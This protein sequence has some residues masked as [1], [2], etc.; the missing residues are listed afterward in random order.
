MKNF[1]LLILSNFVLYTATASVDDMILKRLKELSQYYMQDF[2]GIKYTEVVVEDWQNPKQRGQLTALY[3]IDVDNPKLA[4][5][6]N[7]YPIQDLIKNIDSSKDFE[8]LARIM[9]WTHSRWKHNSV[10]NPSSYAATT[11][12]REA[13]QGGEFVCSAYSSVFTQIA[14]ALG[15]PARPF[16][17]MGWSLWDF[18][19]GHSQTEAWS[20]QYKKWIVFDATNDSP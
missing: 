1:A 19:S 7:D 5:L 16:S 20:N 13:E 11:I 12:L 18:T 4:Q 6:R 15:F 8:A 14:N 17:S 3:F 2:K 9:N 10:A